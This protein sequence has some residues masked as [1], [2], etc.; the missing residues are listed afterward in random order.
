[1]KNLLQYL[2]S[3]ES[4][5]LNFYFSDVFLVINF[6]HHSI[7][8]IYSIEYFDIKIHFYSTLTFYWSESLKKFYN[9]LML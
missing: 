2:I 1:M 3:E 4:Y 5:P 6:K 7:E 8:N 9:H